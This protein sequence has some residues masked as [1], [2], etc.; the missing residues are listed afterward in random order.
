L[1]VY[2]GAAQVQGGSAA[3][4][5]SVYASNPR[6]PRP[7]TNLQLPAGYAGTNGT[8]LGIGVAGI[9]RLIDALAGGSPAHGGRY[10]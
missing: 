7:L 5:P 9:F 8:L 3:V 6:P 2:V 1:C 10:W 4:P